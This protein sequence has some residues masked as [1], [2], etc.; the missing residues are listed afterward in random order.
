MM[1][2]NP[3]NE[4]IVYGLHPVI[5]AIQAGKTIDKILVKKGASGENLSLILKE[6]RRLHI[7]MQY[8]PVEKLNRVTRKNHQ[9]VIAFVSSIDYHR[10]EDVIPAIFEEGK[11]PMLLIL[12]QVTDVRN[13][14]GIARSAE[15]FGVDCIVIPEKGAA[16]VSSD[17]LRTSA[18]AL[19]HVKVCR[20]KNL[21]AS[22]KFMLNSGIKII[23]STEK[24]DK[25]VYKGLLKGP[26]AIIMGSEETG[27]SPELLELASEQLQLPVK[28]KT[29]S[30]NVSVAAGIFLY[31][32]QRQRSQ[33]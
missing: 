30:L 23:A 9:G 4:D 1:K 28:G 15:C 19:N 3:V 33:D 12:D 8:V 21:A 10:L 6:I 26:V 22:M 20:V 2:K 13:F 5:E 32:A 11:D 7:P 29:S 16:R 27:I 18:G 24:A 17:A 14:G 31:E 25:P